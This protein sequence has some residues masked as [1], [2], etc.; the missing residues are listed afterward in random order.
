MSRL[1]SGIVLAASLA[2]FCAGVAHAESQAEIAS[3]ENEDGK[4]LMFQQKYAEASAKFQDAVARVPE[5]KYFFNL[6]MS[7]YQEGKFGEALTACNSVDKNGADDALKG[8]AAKLGD[9][10]KDEAQ[11][12]GLALQPTG[13]GGGETNV[14]PPDGGGTTPPPDGGNAT[15]PPNG[16]GTGAPPAQPYAVGRPPTQGVF[17]SAPP[18]HN[19]TWTLGVDL[20]GGGGRFGAKDVN[21]EDIYGHSAGGVRFKSDYLLNPA[22]KIGAQAYLQITHLTANAMQGIDVSSL[23][24]FDLGLAAYKHLCQGSGRACITPLA[25][26]QLSL[27]SPAGMTD[28]TGSQVFNYAA[29]GGR[30]EVAASYALGTHYE[31]VLSAMIGLNVYTGAFA[32][33]SADQGPPAADIGLD[34][35]GAFAYL[36]IGYTYRFNT[37]FGT[38]PF[39]TLE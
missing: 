33:P 34:K 1:T 21:G 26:V 39:V 37:P 27:L 24:I 17:T 20:F 16:G 22:A 38:A 19:Y 28:G 9:K 23:D 2:A 8:K 35:G 25:G 6:C 14:P 31:H 18:Q 12:Q 4:Q 3:K 11:K 7:L 5:A 15:P 10:I 30:L 36:G 13:G 29:L 32:S